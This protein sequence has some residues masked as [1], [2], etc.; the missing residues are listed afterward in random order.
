MDWRSPWML[1]WLL[2]SIAF[3]LGCYS[4]FI[5]RNAVARSQ[6]LETPM[7]SR[8]MSSQSWLR[9]ITKA[10]LQVLAVA[11][12][13][14]ALAGPQF[15]EQIEVVVPQGRDLYILLDV[16]RS[17]LA[18][19][20]VPSRL[21]RAKAD[22][23]SLVNSLNGERVG[24]I[25][26]AGQAVVKCPLTVDYDYFRSTLA[27]IDVNSAPRGGTA[28]GDAVRKALQVFSANAQRHQAILLITDGDDHSSAPLEAADLAAERNVEIFAVGLGDAA[29]GARIPEKKDSSQFMEHEGE[30]VWSKLDGSLLEKMATRTSGAYIPVG[31]KSYDLK[32]IY[33]NYLSEKESASDEGQTR[34]RRADQYQWFL[35]LS[36]MAL[37]LDLI[38]KPSSREPTIGGANKKPISSRL[39][40]SRRS[41][42]S[43]VSICL[44]TISLGCFS[45]N[46]SVISVASGNDAQSKIQVGIGL[47]NQEK[48]G[49]A[50]QAFA[51]AVD[52]YQESKDEHLH[53]AAF[54]QA[55]AEHRLGNQD[56]AIELYL[57]AGMSRDRLLASKASFNLGR[58]HVESAQKL[59][60]EQE[61]ITELEK[62]EEIVE[63][64][65]Q[66]IAA[67]RHSMELDP[68]D[69][70]ARRNIELVR[71]WLKLTT[72]RWREQDLMKRRQELELIQFLD[73]IIA[74]QDS[75]QQ[76]SQ[77]LKDLHALDQ[78]AELKRSQDELIE[79]LPYLK[80]KIS[81][82]LNPTASDTQNQNSTADQQATQA[83]QMLQSWVD[84]ASEQMRIA[85]SGLGRYRSSLSVKPQLVAIEKLEQLW[86]AVSP[87][88]L[89]LQKSLQ[90]QTSMAGELKPAESAEN[91]Q[92]TPDN[93][94]DQVDLPPIDRRWIHL[95]ER[96]MLRAKTLAPKAQAALA[97]LLKAESPVPTESPL[98]SGS[99][100]QIGAQEQASTTEETNRQDAI[101][102]MQKAIELA[103]QAVVEMQSAQESASRNELLQ[104]WKH[105]DEARRILE[106][107][108]SSQPKPPQ[109]EEKQ[110][111]QKKQNDKNNQENRDNENQG[112]QNN[113]QEKPDKQKPTQED[114]N[115]KKQDG[116]SNSDKPDQEQ[117]DV[118]DEPRENP[119]STSDARPP[120]P[121]RITEAIRKVREREAQKRER[122]RQV[123]EIFSGQWSVEK[124][125]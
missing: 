109:Q 38:V 56:R 50:S 65:R 83:I 22:I 67:Y 104:A 91:D 107:I 124:D 75:I 87:F 112:Q 74:A 55:C 59:T 17:M 24:L 54:D 12:L 9:V 100:E 96:T 27:S 102:G 121:D 69:S 3:W 117:P 70:D 13:I 85:A 49:E 40:S 71:H 111:D 53:I 84:L 2:P 33:V 119:D 7:A 72:D 86:N 93:P 25:A 97:E 44:L 92:T 78:F 26:F 6:F 66:A 116:Q 52:S 82:S 37:M 103:P 90:E 57:Q 101:D 35:A 79:E 110:D 8:L 42:K 11:G 118:K 99:G 36:L 51:E 58:L 46:S 89:T 19:D 29:Q 81:D 4:F 94:L 60:Q 30:Q 113:D 80:D 23:A 1:I 120:T 18:T 77:G 16:S 68:Q 115:D 76:Q 73:Y 15:G 108:A 21:D 105:A 5:Y 114:Q 98:Q 61:V 95:Q 63:H 20:V 125:W 64:V 88:S 48:F 41:A 47:Y 32:G 45:T 31:T 39:P 122:D 123:R 43:E 14:I 28:I 62:R 34:L 106:E 10:V